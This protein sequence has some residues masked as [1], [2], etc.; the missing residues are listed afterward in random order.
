MWTL[1][2]LGPPNYLSVDQVSAYNS[3]EMQESLE[4]SGIILKV[5]PV[6]NPVTKD[7]V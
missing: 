5:A 2:Y 7:T 1:V 4:A 3:R 6:E